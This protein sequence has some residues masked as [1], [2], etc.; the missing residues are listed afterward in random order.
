MP[1][2]SDRQLE[3]EM[4]MEER[5]LELRDRLGHLYARYDPRA[6]VIEIRKRGRTERFA[7]ERYR[8][9]LQE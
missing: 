9:Q 4:R 3:T 5:W 7:L 2:E 1:E 6:E 8:F